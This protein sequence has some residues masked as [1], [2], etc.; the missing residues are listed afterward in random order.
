MVCRRMRQFVRAD[1]AFSTHRSGI[2]VILFFQCLNALLDS[3]NRTG[4][5]IKW[6]LVAHCVA[7]F[8][9]ATLYIG[10]S[11]NVQAISYVDNRYFPGDGEFFTGPFGFLAFIYRY[12]TVNIIPTLMFHLNNLLADGFLVGFASNVVPI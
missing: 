5:R 9:I 12:K 8:S 10:T 1:L 3:V 7:M 2:V 4:R 11:L 6:P